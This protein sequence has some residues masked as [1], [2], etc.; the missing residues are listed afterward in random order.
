[1]SYAT[2]RQRQ[3]QSQIHYGAARHVPLLTQMTAVLSRF[4]L[5]NTRAR[6]SE[7]PGCVSILEIVPVML[8]GSCAR[9][10][11]LKHDILPRHM[12]DRSRQIEY[13]KKVVKIFRMIYRE[14]RYDMGSYNTRKRPQDRALLAASKTGE[15]SLVMDS[16]RNHT[17]VCS[18]RIIRRTK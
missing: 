2:K 15:P 1:M 4:E 10:V 6:Y 17:I 7:P 8:K 18:A 16:Y 3:R 12:M 11:L 9:E 5:H 13:Q 14:N